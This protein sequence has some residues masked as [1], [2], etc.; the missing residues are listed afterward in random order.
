MRVL[1]CFA[2]TAPFWCTGIVYSTK[3]RK[4]VTNLSCIC[5]TLNFKKGVCHLNLQK[6][7]SK[8]LKFM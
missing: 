4:C 6:E 3:E 2:I 5:V 8:I 7:H 1:H